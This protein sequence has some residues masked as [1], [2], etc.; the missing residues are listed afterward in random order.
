MDNL[1]IIECV[2]FDYNKY[3]NLVNKCI[4]NNDTREITLQG[5]VVKPFIT[6]LCE[7]LTVVDTSIKGPFTKNHDYRKYSGTYK[8]HNNNEKPSTPDLLI[9]N[10]WNW[11][12]NENKVEYRAV[13]EVKSFTSPQCIFDKKIIDYDNKLQ[14]QI[15]RHLTA[16][17]NKKV[18][19]TDCLKWEFFVSD[20]NEG[21]NGLTPIKTIELYDFKGKNWEWKKG[22]KSKFELEIFKGIEYEKAP[23]EFEELIKYLVEFVSCEYENKKYPN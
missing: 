16:K 6:A 14:T 13:V 8:D 11:N 3:K 9:A 7:G 23:E 22:E 17:E 1:Q 15:K 20:N 4:E 18:I 2:N 5:D 12:N 21:N 19:L 10:N